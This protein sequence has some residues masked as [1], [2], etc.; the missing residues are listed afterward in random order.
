MACPAIPPSRARYPSP[1]SLPLRFSSTPSGCPRSMQQSH[2]AMQAAASCTHAAARSLQALN[3]THIRVLL[4]PW[5]WAMAPLGSSLKA[6][7]VMSACSCRIGKRKQIEPFKISRKASRGMLSHVQIHPSPIS[8][9][10]GRT[11]HKLQK[12]QICTMQYIQLGRT[13]LLARQ[14]ID[15]NC[16]PLPA[17]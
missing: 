16:R 17:G 13:F 3:C 7:A 10:Q 15:I 14:G 5:L 11:Q 12:I 4:A 8:R 1:P 6:G 2:P 9:Y